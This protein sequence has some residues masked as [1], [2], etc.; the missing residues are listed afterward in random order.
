MLTDAFRDADIGIGISK[1]RYR[2]DGSLFNLRR[3]QAE[4]K[5]ATDTIRDF[6]FADDCALN[7][8]SE[9]D[10]ENSVD[11]FSDACNNFGLSQYEKTEVMH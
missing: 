11:R 6:L 4:T 2:T 7:A 1:S 9:V 8:A 10:M 3:L 5:V